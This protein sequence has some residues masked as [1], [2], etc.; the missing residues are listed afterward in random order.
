MSIHFPL[1]IMPKITPSF[2]WPLLAIVLGLSA[3]KAK[4]PESK[5]DG[6]ATAVSAATA[7]P[8]KAEPALPPATPLPA[9]PDAAP[10]TVQAG[11]FDIDRVPVTQTPLP[12]FPY[13][14]W[15]SALPIEARRV[16][17]EEFDRRYVI[18][19]H[20]A[21]PVEG[22]IEWREFANSAAKLSN[23][24]SQRNYE[25]ALK[26]IGAT[27]VDAVYPFDVPEARINGGE[28]L[29]LDEK[30]H[31][32]P[33]GSYSAYLI[34]TPTKNVWFSLSVN[35]GFTNIM[36]IDEKTMTQSVDVVAQEAPPAK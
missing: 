11:A 23:F 9:P 5:S 31:L 25:N 34:R 19:G 30:F 17:V 16:R 29:R 1:P 3:C 14:D 28:V 32:T 7:A 15:P 13:L 22:H 4:L 35:N 10:A 6:P 36:T 8:A 20:K 26:A 12:P 24:G 33:S 21:L 18:A 27:R 2:R